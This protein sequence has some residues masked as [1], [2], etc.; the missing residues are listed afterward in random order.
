MYIFWKE[1]I[2]AKAIEQLENCLV[3]W[4]IG[5]LTAD[6]HY[7]YGMPIGWCIA[8]PDI[9]SLSGVGFDIGCGNKA[10]K[11][12]R[13][14]WSI[15]VKLAM[16]RISKEIGFWVGRPNPDLVD[17]EVLH[18]IK[19]AAFAPQRQLYD[20]ACQQLGTVWSGNHYVDLFEGDDWH[21]WIGV[22]FW[23]RWFG[24]KTTNGFIAMSQGLTFNDHWKEGAMDSKPILFDMKTDIWQAY[25]EAMSLAGE[26][27]YAGRD[28]VCNK[29]LE[30]IGAKSL[31]EVHN[32]HNFA[33]KEKHFNNDYY[34]VRKGCT[35]AFPWQQWFIGANMLDNSVIVEGVESKESKLGLY[36]TV[37]GAGR[38][39]GRRDAA[40]SRKKKD[41]KLVQIK[42]GKVDFNETKK[43]M[44]DNGVVLVWAWADESPECYKS[45]VEV[46]KYQ[47]NTIKILTELK[48]IG[49]AMAG[50]DILDP[51]KD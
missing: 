14:V 28:I 12:S 9:I 51:Y 6:A 36:S 13:R 38:V 27:A 18:K 39:M 44:K 19:T 30:I 11:T 16:Q 34:V 47:G 20:M 3:D 48:P 21:I 7:G 8:Y 35:P 24:H 41:W 22:H 33:R 32:H 49:V 23:S 40:G 42:A 31:Y 1:I 43:T 37:H 10:I 2:D 17:H 45:L 25:F 5:V 50:P 15:D 46:L 26:Y 4:A 29:V